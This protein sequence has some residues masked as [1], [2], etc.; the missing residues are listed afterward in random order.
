[1][2][3][4]L[5]AVAGSVFLIIVAT[6]HVRRLP[7]I[8]RGLEI[9]AR[10][11]LAP[12]RFAIVQPS[13]E[14]RLIEDSWPKSRNDEDSLPGVRPAWE[15]LALAICVFLFLYSRYGSVPV[16]GGFE[17]TSVISSTIY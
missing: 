13:S 16:I 15:I 7:P 1:M 11:D 8:D 6:S 9:S 17:P 10:P 5:L 4:I 14:F 12:E 3:L 2:K